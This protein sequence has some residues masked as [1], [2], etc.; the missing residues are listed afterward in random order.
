MK[1]FDELDEITKR[2]VLNEVLRGMTLDRASKKFKVSFPQSLKITYKCSSCSVENSFNVF[3]TDLQHM[4]RYIPC[5][6]CGKTMFFTSAS[7]VTNEEDW[8]GVQWG[9]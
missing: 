7:R 9:V 6:K 1:S 8:W 2:A 5:Y 4:S 3:S